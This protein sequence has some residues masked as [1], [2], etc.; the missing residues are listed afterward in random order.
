MTR[1]KAILETLM[2]FSTYG[3]HCGS[4]QVEKESCGFRGPGCASG[5]VVCNGEAAHFTAARKQREKE[6]GVRVLISQ[7][8]TQ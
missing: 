3:E 8:M 5:M 1:G 4:S 2:I 6:E 7:S